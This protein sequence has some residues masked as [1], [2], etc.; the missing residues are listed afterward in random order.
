MASE[1]IIYFE[2]RLPL[3]SAA[4][5]MF[6]A[7]GYLWGNS[8]HGVSVVLLILA[9]L[10]LYMY[11][12]STERTNR[13]V[14]FFFTSLKNN[15]TTQQFPVNIK[16][17]TLS[18]LHEKMNE[19]NR[20]FQAIRMQLEYNEN[21]YK[22]LIKNSATGFVVLNEQNH[23]ELIN[24]SACHYAGIS[25][26]SSNPMQLK[27]RNPDFYDALCNLNAGH[28]MIYKQVTGNELMLLNFKATLLKKEN[29]V[30]KLISVQ[31]IRY[32][33]ETR[34][35]ESY[36][37]LISVMTHEIMN[38]ISPITSA[39]KTLQSFLFKDGNPVT[40]N[41]LD[42]SSLEITQKGVN[43]I[44]EHSAGLKT[45]I[46]N[47]RKISKLPKPVIQNIDTGEWMDQVRIAFSEKMKEN[48]VSFEISKD[49]RIKNIAIDKNLMNQVMINLLNNAIDAVRETDGDRFIRI[50]MH[51]FQ[52]NRV[53]I[54]V[55]NNGPF[56]PQSI[57]DKIF[58]PFF[59][60]KK[61][62][63]GIG[64]SICQEVIKLHNGS[65]SVISKEND[66]TTFNIEL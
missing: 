25:S 46:E 14:A 1:R 66:Y 18:R 22:T 7:S 64:L 60:T 20:H 3:L 52:K 23:I 32:E 6:I 53:K 40:L 36:R 30:L 55:S 13:Q 41:D 56:I 39:S 48:Q 24:D 62:G 58:V 47:Y 34:E 43:L 2:H 4:V 49:N 50:D 29:Q 65:L 9:F 21:Y 63:S 11:L 17:R 27:S 37:K 44:D 8:L 19:A 16:N 33:M 51:V 38:V 12:Q 5:L 28:D 59:T 61:E 31:D 42:A 26:E 10:A 15:D 54:S 45:F 57:Q 35:I